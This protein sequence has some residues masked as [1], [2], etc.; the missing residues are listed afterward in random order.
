MLLSGTWNSWQISAISLSPEGK[1][2]LNYPS[3]PESGLKLDLPPPPQSINNTT[4][5]PYQFPAFK[6]SLP[7]LGEVP[8]Y[9]H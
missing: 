8:V 3:N 9:L 4:M 2:I 7:A 5:E 6:M 1:Q